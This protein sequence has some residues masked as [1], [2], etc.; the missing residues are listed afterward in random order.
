MRGELVR[1]IEQERSEYDRLMQSIEQL[2]RHGALDRS[3]V[4]KPCTS[5]HVEPRGQR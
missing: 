2:Y 3:K 5:K 4:S 1:R